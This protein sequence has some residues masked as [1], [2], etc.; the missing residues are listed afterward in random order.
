MT[1]GAGRRRKRAAQPTRHFTYQ[2]KNEPHELVT[3]SEDEMEEM[4][5]EETKKSV[6]LFGFF[7][8]PLMQVSL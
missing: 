2:F 8:F 4:S 5:P 1:W 6:I 7:I 3:S